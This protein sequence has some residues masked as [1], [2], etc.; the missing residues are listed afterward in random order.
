MQNDL[1]SRLVVSGYGTGGG[2][3]G[4]AYEAARVMSLACSTGFVGTPQQLQTI[5]TLGGWP[6]CIMQQW[7][8]A[9]LPQL[10][11]VGQHAVEEHKEGLARI[12]SN[13]D[14]KWSP[15]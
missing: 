9:W 11:R 12:V 6:V 7:L 5:V 2:I 4:T 3:T 13:T 10:Q 8:Q 1:M 14:V 15:V